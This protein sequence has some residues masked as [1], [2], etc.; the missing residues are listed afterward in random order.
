MP[1]V[2]VEMWTHDLSDMRLTCW[3]LS[4]DICLFSGI[5]HWSALWFLSQALP[6]VADVEDS[7]TWSKVNIMNKTACRS[8]QGLTKRS[9]LS[10]FYTVLRHTNNCNFSYYHNRGTNSKPPIIWNFT[11][12]PLLWFLRNSQTDFIS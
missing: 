2:G 12:L 9:L 6:H 10:K 7:E 4:H 11:Q 5:C 1:S 8:V 3:L